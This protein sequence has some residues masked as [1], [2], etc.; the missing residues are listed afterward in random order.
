MNKEKNFVSLVTFSSR[1]TAGVNLGRLVK[2][3]Y[4]EKVATASCS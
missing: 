2:K 3:S 1:K 4:D